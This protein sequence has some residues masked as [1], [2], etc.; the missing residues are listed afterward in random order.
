MYKIYI[1]IFYIKVKTWIWILRTGE[2][3]GPTMGP[4]GSTS[5]HVSRATLK[6]GSQGLHNQKKKD[7]N[8]HLFTNMTSHAFLGFRLFN[9]HVIKQNPKSIFYI[10]HYICLNMLELIGLN[11]FQNGKKTNIEL[12]IFY[13][14]Y[15]F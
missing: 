10:D 8:F 4:T 1:Y 7:V 5:I 12:M 6:F 15:H 14:I 11:L 9:M 13:S 2:L 3:T